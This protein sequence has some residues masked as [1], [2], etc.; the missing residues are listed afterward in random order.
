M[1]RKSGKLLADLAQ[2]GDEV[3]VA[4]GGLGGVRTKELVV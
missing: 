4:R 2:P 3:L 1:K